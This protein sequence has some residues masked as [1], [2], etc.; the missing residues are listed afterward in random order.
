MSICCINNIINTILNDTTCKKGSILL[1]MLIQLIK[2][3]DND[4]CND[5]GNYQIG[6]AVNILHQVALSHR[7]Y[8]LHIILSQVF[9]N[10]LYY[11]IIIIHSLNILGTQLSRYYGE[12]AR[13]GAYVK[14]CH[15]RL[16]KLFQ[17]LDAHGC[18]SMS[19]CTKSST[20][21]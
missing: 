18:G 5:I 8:I 7:H 16:N 14:H 3:P 20:R 6:L 1:Q 13:A 12:D 15:S 2:K 17:F 21:I 11:G 9:F 4:I 10:N 19:A